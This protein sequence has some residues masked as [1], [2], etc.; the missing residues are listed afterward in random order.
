MPM[1]VRQPAETHFGRAFLNVQLPTAPAEVQHD[2]RAC[3]AAT[4]VL[5]AAAGRVA[6]QG[7]TGQDRTALGRAM[8]EAV[9]EQHS[10]VI[11]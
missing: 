7:M 11:Q 3:S 4:T 6:G 10:V 1:T 2:A 9:R 8:H 5:P